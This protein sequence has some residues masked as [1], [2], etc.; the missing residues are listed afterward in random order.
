MVVVYLLFES[1]PT[2]SCR[3]VSV[4]GCEAF[5]GHYSWQNVRRFRGGSGSGVR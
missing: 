4:A 3:E 5:R 1:P 2:D